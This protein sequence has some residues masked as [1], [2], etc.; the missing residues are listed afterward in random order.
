[1]IHVSPAPNQKSLLAFAIA[2]FKNKRYWENNKKRWLESFIRIIEKYS[3][4]ELTKYIVYKDAATPYTLYRYTL[5]YKRRGLWMGLY[6]FAISS[7]DLRKPS[8]IQNFYLSGHWTTLGMGIP[9]VFILVM[10]LQN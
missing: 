2:P 6:S 7:S 8:F 4:P 9:G 5:N 3:I 1:M 10:I